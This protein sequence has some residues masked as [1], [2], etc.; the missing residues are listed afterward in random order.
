MAMDIANQNERRRAPRYPAL[1]EHMVEFDIPSALVYQ[2][3]CQ[4]VSQRGVG[5]IVKPDSKFLTLVQINQQLRV[6]IL[7]PAGSLPSQGIYLIRIAHITPSIE[8]RFKGHV[9][10]GLELV[11]KIADY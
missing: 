3:K 2:L 11:Q 4:D 7:S 9:V 8:G 10:V 1:S 5:V 6:K